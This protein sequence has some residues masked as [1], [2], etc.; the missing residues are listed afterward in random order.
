M[1]YTYDQNNSG[2]GFSH[3]R[4]RG[5]GYCVS[6]EADNRTEATNKARDIGIYFDG[7]YE[8]IDC[9]CCGDRWYDS[10]EEADEPLMYGRP[11]KG[12][13]GVPSYIHYKDG[14]IEERASESE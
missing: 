5:I 13:W 8:G 1:F 11:V 10:P 12:G 6:I 7:C 14:R 9:S 3:N 4:E 2:G